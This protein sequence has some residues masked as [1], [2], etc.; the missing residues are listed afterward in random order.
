MMQRQLAF[1]AATVK[2]LEKCFSDEN[3]VTELVTV[4][5]T[6]GLVTT[7]ICDILHEFV[8]LFTVICL[9]S[10]YHR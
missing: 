7:D 1:K 6:T 10:H 4:T 8:T 9:H 2:S 5:F 3:D